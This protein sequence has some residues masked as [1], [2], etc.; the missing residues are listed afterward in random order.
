MQEDKIFPH[1]ELGST[2]N[3]NHSRLGCFGLIL[4]PEKQTTE[5]NMDQGWISPS[6]SRDVSISPLMDGNVKLPCVRATSD[7]GEVSCPHM[8]ILRIVKTPC[9]TLQSSLK[10][11]SDSIW[12]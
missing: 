7:Y 8:E 3:G 5:E 10:N 9:S 1:T 4:N 2:R 6:V 12:A 11:Q